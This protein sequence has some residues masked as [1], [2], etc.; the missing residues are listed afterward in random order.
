MSGEV[1]LLTE[2]VGYNILSRRKKRKL[3]QEA[4]ADM[5][6]IGQQ[7]LSRME[8]GKIAPRFDRLQRFAE[9]LCCTVADLFKEGETNGSDPLAE[10]QSFMRPLSANSQQV[11][12]NI[13]F[14]VAK[15]MLRLERTTP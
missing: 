4:L 14:E 13:G 7:S 3:T 11:V 9:V 10:L 5:V 8:K 1:K 15:A 2:I 12:V 6:G